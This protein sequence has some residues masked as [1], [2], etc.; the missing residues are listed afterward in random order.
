MLR[1]SFRSAFIRVHPRLILLLSMSKRTK[2]PA[3]LAA[4][5]SFS[6]V[7]LASDS[8]YRLAVFSFMPHC[9]QVPSAVACCTPSHMAQSSTPP[10]VPV[11]SVRIV[12]VDDVPPFIS[13]SVLRSF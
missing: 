3:A 12:V 1:P 11:V 4:G 6:P 10:A 5:A 2:T 7:T 8:A 9:G 13:E